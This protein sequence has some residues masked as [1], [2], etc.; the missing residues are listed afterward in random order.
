[1][2][3][4]KILLLEDSPE[5][6][7]LTRE[8]LGPHDRYTLDNVTHIADFEN[9]V[10]SQDYDIALLDYKLPD[11]TALDALLYMA[12]ASIKTPA[13]VVTA[14]GDEQ[15]AVKLVKAGAA[16]YIVK[17]GD[18]LSALPA[19]MD[20]VVEQ[21]RLKAALEEAETR[22]TDLFVQ[23][24]EGILICS[25]TGQILDAN[26]TLCR[27]LKRSVE[28]LKDGWLSD[29]NGNSLPQ[30]TEWVDEVKREKTLT[31]EGNLQRSDGSTFPAEI[32]AHY[33]ATLNDRRPATIQIFVHDITQRRQM[34]T[35]NA[36]LISGL[37][38][39]LEAQKQM[40]ARLI[41]AARFSAIG[42]L[43]A[44]VAHQISNPLTTILADT[45]LLVSTIGEEHPGHA[46]ATAI[47]EAGWRAQRVVQRLV[48]FAQPDE[49]QYVAVNVN[50][51]IMNALDFVGSHL[52]KS[53]V[54]LR[55]VLAETLPEI[56]AN[57]Q[58]LEEIWINLLLNAREALVPERR[59]IISINSKLAAKGEAIEV[60]VV[61]NGR[62]I[63][64]HD[65]SNIFT[66]F[67]TTKGS[68]RGN[69]L[70]LS[71][72]QTIAH[73]HQG[74]ITFDSRVGLGTAFT[75]RLPL[76]RDVQ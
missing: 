60:M 24:V 11:G 41:R 43:A 17:T 15:V 23:A 28:E 52:D 74:E 71:V 36:R 2:M 49:E 33:V 29:I 58:Q 32:T 22:Y 5:F 1:M 75:V 65:K 31:Y 13:I 8:F 27:W 69:G 44:G 53:V 61:D 18:Y 45:Q 4:L 34:E 66:P 67:F 6:I 21:A 62:G 57:E 35:E 50:E 30:L 7:E 46:S 51:T 10:S 64:E 55:L 9:K 38:D 56:S 26:P 73:N 63:A 40:Q 59:G 72:C 20:R 16:D 25:A 76:K 19:V 47:M 42:E 12:S 3:P 14:R 39:A 48:N 70:G 68:R 37:Q 54:D